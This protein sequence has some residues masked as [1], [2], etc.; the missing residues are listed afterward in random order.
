MKTNAVK[1]LWLNAAA[2]MEYAE[3]GFADGDVAAAA[4]GEGHGAVGA[5]VVAAVLDLQERPRTA[6]DAVGAEDGSAWHRG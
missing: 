2:L 1:I 4:A 3:D 6:A 5:E